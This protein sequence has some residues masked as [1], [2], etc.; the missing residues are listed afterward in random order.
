MVLAGCEQF[1][2]ALSP[3]MLDSCVLVLAGLAYN[4]LTR[5]PWPHVQQPSAT[6]PSG[7]FSAADL[8]AA[9]AHYNQ[10]L[11]VSREDLQALLERAE[12]SA[13]QRNMGR[14]AAPRS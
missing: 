2:Y 6:P 3:V 5:R 12:A 4:N 14:F 13:Y 9:L 11:D 10:V 7:R 8:D 1:H